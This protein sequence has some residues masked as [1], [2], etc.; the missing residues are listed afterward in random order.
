[1]AS[2]LAIVSKAQFEA[3]HDGAALGDVLAIDRYSSAHKALGVLASGGALFVVTVR[4]PDEQ[5]W[6]LAVLEAPSFDGKG[7]T[8]AANRAPVRDIS[9]LRTKLKFSTGSGIQAKPGA[10]GMSLQTPRALTDADVALLSGAKPAPV[11][12]PPAPTAAPATGNDSLSRAARALDAGD[13]ESALAALAEAWRDCRAPELEALIDAVSQ[14]AARAYSPI[15]GDGPAFDDAWTARERQR[16][17]GDLA[18]LV[19]GL[20]AD[21]RGG[22]PLR[23]RTLLDWDADPRLGAAMLRMVDKPP[24]TASSN[25]SAWTALFAAL[26]RYADTRAKKRL[27]AR[28]KKHD[29]NSQFWPKLTAWIEA[30]LDKL[31]EPAQLSATDGERIRALTARAAKLAAGPAPTAAAPA[32]RAVEIRTPLAR[33]Q[34]AASSLETGNLDT[35]LADLLSFWAERRTPAVADLIERLGHL[36]AN[37]TAPIDGNAAEIHE[38]WMERGRAP[39]PDDITRLLETLS[40][41][42]TV[43]AEERLSVMLHWPPDPRV[44]TRLLALLSDYMI[45]ERPTLW[46]AVNELL[47][48]HADPRIRERLLAQRHRHGTTTGHAQRS[49]EA[50]EA[51]CAKPNALDG[52]E[53][54]ALAAVGRALDA[55]SKAAEASRRRS[56][57]TDAALVDAIVA[58]FDADEPRLVYADILS[59]RGDARGPYIA[60]A[61]AQTRGGKVKS[62][63]EEHERKHRNELLGPLVQIVANKGGFVRGFL[64]VVGVRDRGVTWNDK[65]AIEKMLADLRW[66]TVRNLGFSGYGPRDC[67]IILDRA[68]LRSL[69]R[70]TGVNFSELVR[71]ANQDAPSPL[72]QVTISGHGDSEEQRRANIVALTGAEQFL[73]KLAEMDLGSFE[74]VPRELLLLPL[75]QR[76]RRVTGGHTAWGGI[77][78]VDEWVTR[79]STAK[80]T[81]TVAVNCSVIGFELD[82]AAR[83][84]TLDLSRAWFARRYS[85][86]GDQLR[87]LRSIPSGMLAEVHAKLG[88]KAPEDRDEILAALAH[89]RPTVVV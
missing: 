40:S 1:L 85:D 12:A 31:P 86:W 23:L 46:R 5:L 64:D 79:V 74:P 15:A 25:F 54:A 55:K 17:A 83:R 7:W 4:P 82:A 8:A 9:Q 39:R 50:F 69:H 24:F 63:L 61:I 68:P 87:S 47:V 6:L 77:M 51:I 27:A 22:I 14:D 45:G 75:F 32:A 81:A 41:G 66:A 16:R 33:L 18:H 72:E 36:A 19:E 38:R 3:Q 35:A 37:T 43:D 11:A 53:E 2:V 76:L 56:E 71:L 28:A 13:R 89:L 57:D 80:L 44:A 20:A 30:V 84:L 88:E 62:K 29:G 21:P 70:L 52:N 34:S 10:L 60:L 48:L 49:R 42:K 73:P 67:M 26:P 78:R 59:E 58:D 65:S